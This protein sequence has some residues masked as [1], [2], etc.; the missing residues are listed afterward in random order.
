MHSHVSASFARAGSLTK[1]L[2]STRSWGGG[3]NN[4]IWG[5]QSSAHVPQHLFTRRWIPKHSCFQH[6][7][8]FPP[9]CEKTSCQIP[10]NCLEY[11]NF[12]M[13]LTIFIHVNI[14]AYATSRDKRRISIPW[15]V[16]N[17]A[18]RSDILDNPVPFIPFKSLNP[19]HTS[20]GDIYGALHTILA[21]QKKGER[22]LHFSLNRETLHCISVDEEKAKKALEQ[23]LPKRTMTKRKKAQRVV[24]SD[25][26]MPDFSPVVPSGNVR[27][28]SIPVPRAEGQQQINPSSNCSLRADFSL[29][30]FPRS[31]HIQPSDSCARFGPRLQ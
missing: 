5:S 13:S 26:D 18:S 1:Y 12:P 10:Y 27:S 8:H 28:E 11:V 16:L 30:P 29:I 14:S 7:H 21:E 9:G 15:N 25:E 2:L 24:Q 31:H 23:P 3:R 20:I 4:W 19:T 22:P 6:R 17:S